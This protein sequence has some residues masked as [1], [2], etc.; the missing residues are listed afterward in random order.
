MFFLIV[1]KKIFCF[2][3]AFLD[4]CTFKGVVKFSKILSGVAR[5]GGDRFRILGGGPR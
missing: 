2:V 1:G 3:I 5:T 4:A